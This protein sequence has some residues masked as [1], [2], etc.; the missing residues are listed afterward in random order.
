MQ[1]NS[2]R[3][4]HTGQPDFST[5]NKTSSIEVHLKRDRY[6]S[7][8]YGF[9]IPA[10]NEAQAN[11]GIRP[12]IQDETIDPKFSERIQPNQEMDPPH[13]Q[14]MEIGYEDSPPPPTYERL[15]QRFIDEIV[16]LARER[17]DA[18]DAEFTR[19]KERILEI[20]REYREKLSSLRAQQATRRE[21]FLSKEL[22]T[23]L[24]QYHEGKRKHCPNMKVPDVHGY[25][26]FTAGESISRFGGGTEYKHDGEQTKCLSSGRSQ[27][28]EVRVPLPPGRVYNNSAVYNNT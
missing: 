19:H 15:E 12:Y 27:G 7:N 6:G 21:E 20:D 16:K 13:E 10:H 22:Q 23:R 14:D 25:V 26:T 18:E 24:N 5:E 9:P 3:N 17:S 11:N 8:V 4:Y 1:N 28:S 2:V